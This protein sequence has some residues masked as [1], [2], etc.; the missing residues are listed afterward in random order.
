M[1]WSRRGRTVR[2]RVSLGAPLQRV[3]KAKQHMR[4]VYADSWMP[5]EQA[6]GIRKLNAWTVPIP[7]SQ[8]RPIVEQIG[9]YNLFKPSRVAKVLESFPSAEVVV[10][11]EN[12]PVL[13]I[14]PYKED[15]K[16]LESAMHR[17]KANEV[18]WVKSYPSKVIE[19]EGGTI[20]RAWWD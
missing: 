1:S 4:G 20:L 10:G 14:Y 5:F 13:Y 15:P 6:A 11:R 19:E 18:G 2:S 8:V 7:A 17:L 12:S 9:T 16:R 3:R